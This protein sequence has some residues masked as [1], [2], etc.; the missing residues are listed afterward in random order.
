M[1]V[2]F[3]TFSTILGIT[4]A[5]IGIQ[6]LIF[7][8]RVPKSINTSSY[9]MSR[10]IFGVAFLFGA[11]GVGIN[12]KNTLFATNDVMTFILAV[13]SYILAWLIFYGR[14]ILNNPSK[15]EKR[16]FIIIGIIGFT[17]YIIVDITNFIFQDPNHRIEIIGAL[18]YTI[19][20]IIFT[21]TCIHKDNQLIR[22]LLKKKKL[23]E[24]EKITWM[25]PAMRIFN[26]LFFV[27]LSVYFFSPSSAIIAKVLNF[28]FFIY[29]GYKIISYASIFWSVKEKADSNF[30]PIGNEASRDF[31]EST[32]NEPPN[33]DSR[34]KEKISPLV[35]KWV[36]EEAYCSPNANINFAAQQ[37]GTNRSYL[38]RFIN[39]EYGI[40]YNEWINNL[41]TRKGMKLLLLHPD[42]SIEEISHMVGIK[43]S[44]N[45]SHWFKRLNG[46]SP[47]QYRKRNNAPS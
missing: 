4:V 47:K 30:R 3:D 45:F 1:N 15:A 20:Y 12:W 18:V 26:L 10:R 23:E 31:E 7:K 14:Y 36:K 40:S 6:L 13:I 28:I 32:E 2:I 5:I 16:K 19:F 24:I 29:L 34:I 46:I 42:K 41:R 27:N 44:Y 37:M 25:Q 33:T 9:Q 21:I 43:K 11:I 17:I 22:E 39:V 38:S 35:E 8:I